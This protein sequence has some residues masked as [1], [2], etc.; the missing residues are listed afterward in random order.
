MQGAA[1]LE[2]AKK[3]KI[4]MFDK[5]GTLTQGSP[6]VIHQQIFAGL[7]AD[8]IML[9]A[10][11]AETSS[12]HPL[13]RAIMAHADAFR[14]TGACAFDDKASVASSQV[15]IIV[16]RSNGS[17]LFL[18]IVS[19][20]EYAYWRRGLHQARYLVIIVTHHRFSVGQASFVVSN[21]ECVR[22]APVPLWLLMCKT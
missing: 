18:F 12:E 13:A 15:G 19:F 14:R 8:E 10:A 16:E 11:A 1:A 5:T 7:P 17:E 4:V 9:L 6:A 21:S 22:Q 3:V 2:A 20:F